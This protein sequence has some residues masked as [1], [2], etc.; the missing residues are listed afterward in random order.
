MLGGRPLG[1]GP[2]SNPRHRPAGYI[3]S[4]D[5]FAVDP[6]PA[7][8]SAGALLLAALLATGGVFALCAAWRAAKAGCRF[9]RKDGEKADLAQAWTEMTR[10]PATKKTNIPVTGDRVFTNA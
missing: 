7:D 1:G 10:N 4:T 6:E 9:R 8:T 5:P 2:P 3:R